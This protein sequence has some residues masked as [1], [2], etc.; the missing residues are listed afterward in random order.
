[1]AKVSDG[2]TEDDEERLDGFVDP[3]QL[4]ESDIREEL[5]D[6]PRVSDNA[7]SAFASK[8]EEKRKPVQ[9]AARQ[10]LIGSLRDGGATGRDMINGINEDGRNVPVGTVNNVETEV[11]SNGDVVARNT[12]TG[13]EGVVGSVDLDERA[14]WCPVLKWC[15]VL[16]IRTAIRLCGVS[17]VGQ[18]IGC[19][20][21]DWYMWHTT[22]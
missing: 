10:E 17:P 18:R 5:E 19:I 12:R 8:I 22:A 2:I 1:M 6:T 3:T 9:N 15:P 11:R 4:G 20:S 21:T 14:Q 7:A 13:T 16:S